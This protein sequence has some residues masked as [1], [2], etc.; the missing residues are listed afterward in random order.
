MRKKAK[1]P[2]AEKLKRLSELLTSREIGKIYD[3]SE[4]TVRSWKMADRNAKKTQAILKSADINRKK[5]TKKDTEKPQ[6]KAKNDDFWGAPT[7][8]PQCRKYIFFRS[9]RKCPYCGFLLDRRKGES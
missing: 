9:A 4:S 2:D 1:R 6:E 3:V 5:Q 7:H 8:C